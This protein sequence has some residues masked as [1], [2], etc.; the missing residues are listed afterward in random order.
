MEL[1]NIC[2]V[3][4]PILNPKADDYKIFSYIQI[5]GFVKSKLCS[6]YLSVVSVHR[7]WFSI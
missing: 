3:S 1:E 2:L 7:I 6:P 4:V 5:M